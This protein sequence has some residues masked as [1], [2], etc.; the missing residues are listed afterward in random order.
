MLDDEE[1][2]LDPIRKFMG[3]QQ[4]SIFENIIYFLQS[5]NANFDY[6]STDGI[7]QLQQVKESKTPYKGNLMQEA[8]QAIDTIKTEV[9]GKI[10]EE[11]NL[12]TTEITNCIEKLKAYPDFA[13]LDKNKQDEILAPFTNTIASIGNER[14]IGNI[15]AKLSDI[16][17][18]I[19]SEQL[20]KMTLMA[21]PPKPASKDDTK[22]A[23]QPIPKVT[24]ILN[25]SI[26]VKYNKPSLE[27]EGNLN[28]YVSELKEEY[29]KIIKDNKRISL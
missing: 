20:D 4:K 9:L 19:F 1:D 25:K 10:T 6:M 29:I 13:K 5:D 16:Q 26:K 2:L 28:G 23:D 8:K 3:G 18:Q 15:R 12:A 17:T 24:Y 7:K 22:T 27:T 21:N 11:R 14:F